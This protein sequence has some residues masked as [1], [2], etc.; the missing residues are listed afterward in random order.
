MDEKNNKNQ[1]NNKDGNKGN[2]FN[3]TILILLIAGVI[4]VLGISCVNTFLHNSTSQE[5][6]YSDFLKMLD[7]GNVSKVVY[8][9]D[10]IEITPKTQPIEGLKLSYYTGYIYDEEVIQYLKDND[11]EYSVQIQDKSS[12]ILDF[13]LVYIVPW[14]LIYFIFSFVFRR[15]SGG[16]GMMGVGKSN[17]KMYGME[18]STGVTFKDVAGQD[19]AKESLTEIVDFLHNPAKYTHI[20]AKLPKGALLVGPPG[21]G[22]TLLAKAVAGEAGVPF[23]SLSGSDFVEMFVGVGASRVRD[24][25]KEA[26]KQAP[27]IIFID[28]IDAIGK[29]RDTR[30]GGNDEREQT[31]NQL[32]AEMD[33]FDTSKGILILAATNRPE[34][35][36]K[37]LLRPGRF[38][39]R[40]I[41]DKPD[42]KGRIDT[43]KVHSKDV[44]MDD[45]VDLEAIGLATSGAVG[46]DLANMINEA[47]IAAVKD[48]RKVVSQ[49]DLFEAVEVVIAG[50]EKKDRILS[51]EEK[52]TVA[53]HEVGHALITALK[54]NAE[55]VQKITI[56]PRTMGSLG[57]VMQVPE[58][59]KYLMTKDELMTR[60]VTLLG[61]RAAEE[62]VFDT[63][64]TGASNDIEKAT[65][66]ARAMITQ[67]GMSEK[68]GLMSLETVES[69]YLDGSARL[70]CSDET[71]AM[72][73]DEVK[74][75]LKECFAEAKKLLSE[76]RDV[77]DEIAKYLYEKETITGKQFME[78]YRKVKGIPEPVDTSHMTISEKVAESVSFNEDGSYSSTVNQAPP[79]PWEHPQQTEA[80]QPSPEQTDKDV[81]AQNTEK[82]EDRNTE[83]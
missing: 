14:V 5:I 42:L 27:C 18:K 44:L 39:R 83:Q 51:K 69:K 16:G 15:M 56:V 64:T 49:K 47:A 19:E 82:E 41:V 74:E 28:E 52:R 29:S 67:Y 24:L 78:I 59:E 32:L 20:G 31:L 1:N 75:L 50:K 72:I 46:S 6:S 34:V 8:N 79:A 65:Q 37:A 40:I 11:I 73:D 25:F 80:Q 60:L 21:T 9:Q 22:K 57:Y 30:Y 38:D 53:Y 23:F 76:N 7:N 71:A 36:D 4:T 70:N 33:G 61:G 13:V 54:K 43:L 62:V 55:P 3:Q 17:A 81:P 45:T 12:S 77:L 63:V 2:R 10:V 58:E 48:G 26:Q 66:I 68:F 35:L